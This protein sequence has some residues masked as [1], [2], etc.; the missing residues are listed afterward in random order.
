MLLSKKWL[1]DYVFLPGS[2]DPEELALKLKL[3]TVEVEGI[4]QQGSYLDQVVVGLIKSVEKHP[5]A[6]R[7]RVCQVDAGGETVQIVCGGSNVAEGMKVALGKL[8]ARVLWH[9]EGEPVVLEKTTI[10]GVDS[11]GMICGADEIGLA[12]VFP[13][14]G[15]KEI[16]DLSHLKDKP[17]TPLRQALVLDDVIFEIDNKSLSNRPDLWGHLGMAREIAAIYRKELVLPKPPVL[18]PGKDRVLAVRNEAPELCGRYMAAVVSG[19]TVGPSPEYIQ[20]RL[21]AV[22]IRPINNIVDATNYCMLDLGQP[23]HAFDLDRVSSGVPTIVVRR[24]EAGESISALDG[25]EYA[26]TPEMLVIANEEKPMAIAGV[27]GGTET[28]VTDGTVAVVLESANFAASSIRKTSGALGIRTESSSR[29]EKTLDQHLCELA[30][31]RVVQL[32]QET[33]PKAVVASNI[34]DI[35]KEQQETRT[36]IVSMD[37]IVGKIGIDIEKKT[38]V[39]IL[40]RLGFAIKEKK[41][42]MAITVPTWRATKDVILKEDIVE[43]VARMFGYD[44]IPA[45]LPTYPI[46]PPAQ[47]PVQKTE[48]IIRSALAQDCAMSEVYNY[49]FVSPQVLHMLRLDPASHVELD[50][51]IAKDRPFLRRY[52]APGLIENAEQNLHRFDRVAMFE[53]GRTYL[54]DEPGDRA[55]PNGDEL[56]PKQDHML[57]IVYAE[58][59]NGQPFYEVSDAVQAMAKRLDLELIIAPDAAPLPFAHTGRAGRIVVAGT[60]VG[61]VAELHPAVAE[62]IGIKTR[63]AV[64]EMNVTM[65]ADLVGVA[66]SEYRSVSA[67]PIVE[68]DVAFIVDKAV[69]HEHMV[70]VL[71][72][73]DPLITS[74]S[75]F[76][77]FEGGTIAAGKKSVAYRL[78]YRSLER[79]LNTS[80]VD[81][82]HARV[83]ET[84]KKQLKGSIRE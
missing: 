41:K 36:I 26:L 68:R 2:Q 19:I 8:G 58:K 43:E 11:F 22:G 20:K 27:M 65:L 56:L 23:L 30:L 52:M 5:D 77:V 75:L 55:E 53:L 24:A 47:S 9:G 46:Q 81:A 28:A 15:E 17:G 71:R 48:R 67:Y 66:P 6:D 51:P 12:D 73:I 4:E 38:V 64:A 49:S 40:T 44:N 78:I 59:G 10:R 84:V 82:V 74:V 32:I 25:S 35:Q 13:K 70:Q 45:S 42:D 3:T 61:Y 18:K 21:S 37:D 69:S 83:I 76:D 62:N 31:R 50:N 1:T 7:L 16:L 80:E 33:C 63:A 54:M 39:D 60:E 72:A 57:G 34:V 29:F 14:T 79:T